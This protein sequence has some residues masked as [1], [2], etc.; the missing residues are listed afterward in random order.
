[1]DLV[2]DL[3]NGL[4]SAGLLTEE[5]GKPRWI[6]QLLK[7]FIDKKGNYTSVDE[8]DLAC[9]KKG[10]DW[11]PIQRSGL[12]NTEKGGL[13][14]TDILLDLL[15]EDLDKIERPLLQV[16]D[17]L[18]KGI[19][20]EHP[21]DLLF[22]VSRDGLDDFL[23]KFSE[24]KRRKCQVIVQ[25]SDVGEIQAY[26]LW[27]VKRGFPQEGDS[28]QYKYSDSSKEQAFVWEDN[29]FE[30]VRPKKH[31]SIDIDM[32]PEHLEKIGIVFFGRYWGQQWK[33]QQLEQIQ[34]Q[35]FE[36]K[37]KIKDATDVLERLK[38]IHFSRHVIGNI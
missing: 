26:A 22:L 4:C 10:K 20:T 15:S 14:D 1:M 19:L 23:K 6:P 27:D 36:W 25:P 35:I 5:N 30:E 28:I 21:E 32:K 29:K 9:F 2:V 17:T 33:E 37:E 13:P 3:R 34:F 31:K 24:K 18:L 11:I 16:V 38:Q 12:P 8:A 7:T